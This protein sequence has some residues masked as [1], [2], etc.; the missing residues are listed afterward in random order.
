MTNKH[1][2]GTINIVIPARVGSNRIKLKN[3][4]ILH[5]KPLISY[6][7]DVA[8]KFKLAKAIY[9]NSDGEVFE[10]IAIENNINFYKRNPDL[11]TTESLIDEYL[12]DFMTTHTSDYLI[13]L[14]PTSP[15]FKID[16]LNR[17]W[18]QFIN[19]DVNTQLSCQRIQ[20]HCFL[21]NSPI[22]FSQTLK[23]QR[24]QDVEP[25]MALNFAVTIWKTSSFIDCY[26]KNGYGV[27]HGDIGLFETKDWESIDIDYEEDFQ[28]AEQ[29][30]RFLKNGQA[31]PKEY[32]DFVKDFLAQNPN[33]RT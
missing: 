22:N 27:H 21:S 33:P 29:I 9:L 4:R 8:K 32:P 30:S 18:E 7:I 11:A 1:K 5:D 19:S 26:R 31:Y 14:N 28:I 12:Y 20:T 16:G 13:L 25:V 15:F 2:D 10:K 24:T 6:A 3:L 23:H 17:A